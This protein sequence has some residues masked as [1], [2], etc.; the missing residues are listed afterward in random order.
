MEAHREGILLYVGHGV[1]GTG[2]QRL[3][4]LFELHSIFCVDF[5]DLE[6][7]L[8]AP[9]DTF[10]AIVVPG[11]DPI[12]QG[13]TIGA[14]GL[15][16]IRSFVERGGGYIG[17]C[18]GA[19]LGGTNSKNPDFGLRLLDVSIVSCVRKAATDLRGKVQVKAGDFHDDE[20][21]FP[22][23]SATLMVNYRNGP[24]F[25]EGNVLKKRGVSIIASVVECSSLP[26]QFR[27]KMHRKPCIVEGSFG[28]GRVV[29]CG[30]HPE[31]TDGLEDFTWSLFEKVL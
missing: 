30:P 24:L 18:A 7:D 17:F 27:S 4:K 28:R 13:N 26:K 9:L 11:G 6:K 25:P 3:R 2:P 29:L 10:Q 22:D 31:H 14:E 15:K 12:Q 20:A 5:V 8:P 19:F 16:K 23:G 1:G 21:A